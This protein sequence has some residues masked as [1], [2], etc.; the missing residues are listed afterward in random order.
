VEPDAVFCVACCDP[1]AAGVFAKS[2]IGSGCTGLGE[3][4]LIIPVIRYNLQ[5]IGF[6]LETM[7]TQLIVWKG[8]DPEVLTRFPNFRRLFQ[9]NT[10]V[11]ANEKTHDFWDKDKFNK[12]SPRYVTWQFKHRHGEHV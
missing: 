12:R 8:L 5:Y 7:F 11:L 9:T 3:M 10:H 6:I 2:S 4:V 1:A